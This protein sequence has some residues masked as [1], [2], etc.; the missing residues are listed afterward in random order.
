M[1]ET[2]M[3]QA[4][5]NRRRGTSRL[6]AKLDTEENKEALISLV[7]QTEGRGGPIA[8]AP[9]VEAA[10]ERARRRLRRM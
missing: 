8:G 9:E 2:F 10:L 6:V 7:A 1:R 4:Q 5:E 3:G